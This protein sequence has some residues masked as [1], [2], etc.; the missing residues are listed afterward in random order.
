MFSVSDKIPYERKN[1]FFNF[2]EYEDYIWFWDVI[3]NALY[4]CKKGES[5]T[6][7]MTPKIN[8][9]IFSL[10][11]KIF[12]Y[13]NFI[14]NIL[15]KESDL[16]RAQFLKTSLN[17]IDFSDSTIEGIIVSIQ[18]IKGAT[19]NQFQ[20]IDLMNLLGVKVK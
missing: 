3:Y 9:S 20:A 5:I 10:Y 17:G 15:F 4:R 7:R 16:T 8:F 19:V 11:S 2:V 14:K 6:Q 12:L 13:E 1:V 18:D